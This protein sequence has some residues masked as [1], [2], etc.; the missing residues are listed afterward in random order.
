MTDR[1]DFLATAFASLSLL[2][3]PAYARKAAKPLKI[4][5]LGGTGFLGPQFV[6]VARARGH[7]LTLFNRGKTNP[8]RFAGEDYRDEK[9]TGND[10]EKTSVVG[11][12]FHR[13][14]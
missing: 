6:E 2:A 12:N 7:T 14:M 10:P 4:L 1:R 8:E 9:T 3:M 5:V 13:L 11:G